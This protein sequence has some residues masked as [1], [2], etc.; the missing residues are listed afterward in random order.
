MPTGV[1]LFFALGTGNIEGE[2]FCIFGARLLA[3]PL[4][5]RSALGRGNTTAALSEAPKIQKGSPSMFVQPH[6]KKL[7]HR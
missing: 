3:S 1:S 4:G 2:P 7:K 5:S 6:H